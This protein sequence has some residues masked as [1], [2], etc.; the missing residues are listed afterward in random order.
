MVYL[1][2][3]H[4]VHFLYVFVFMPY[5]ATLISEVLWYILKSGSMMLSPAENHLFL[6]KI[7]LAIQYLLWFHIHF[8]MNKFVKKMPLDFDRD[9]IESVINLGSMDILTI[10]SLLI[11]EYW[12]IFN[13]LCLIYFSAIFICLINVYIFDQCFIYN[14]RLKRSSY[15]DKRVNSFGRYSNYK[16]ISM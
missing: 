15:N 12:I 2:D 6:L 7:P 5:H 14:K 10:L 8:R 9:F 3:F 16:C 4:F 1:W 11:H 13:Y